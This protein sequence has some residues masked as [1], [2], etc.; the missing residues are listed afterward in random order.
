M[1][2]KYLS[3]L[4][5]AFISLSSQGFSSD[6]LRLSK[7]C[8]VLSGLSS[9][10]IGDGDWLKPEGSFDRY[11]SLKTIE[12]RSIMIPVLGN[13]LISVDDLTKS[14]FDKLKFQFAGSVTEIIVAPFKSSH[15][16]LVADEISNISK[17]D[18]VEFR[19]FVK[20]K[21]FREQL[22][23]YLAGLR[24][25]S[26]CG[27]D[28]LH[29]WSKVYVEEILSTAIMNPAEGKDAQVFGDGIVYDLEGGAGF[30]SVTNDKK[31][32]LM[33]VSYKD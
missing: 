24:S 32:I 22:E 30:I 29:S 16:D 4:I 25:G 14:R 12:Y 23:S 6:D 31:Y 20:T 2:S 13:K 7:I 18:G 26:S 19:E 27:S 9:E 10:S 5:L 21:T 3:A 28:L 33:S 15:F 8:R 1:I 11:S 17:Q